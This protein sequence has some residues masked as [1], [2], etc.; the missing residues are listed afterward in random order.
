M[1]QR[2]AHE[3]LP[4]DYTMPL[5][6]IS[7]TLLFTDLLAADKGENI[8]SATLLDAQIAMSYQTPPWVQPASQ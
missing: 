7:S 8:M 4:K 3:F 1:D 6:C 5:D 2:L